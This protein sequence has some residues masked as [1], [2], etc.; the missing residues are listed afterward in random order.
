MSKLTCNVGEY[1]VIVNQERKCLILRLPMNEEFTRE[2]WM[3][4]GGRLEDDDQPIS[5]L[6]REI[7]EE[8]CLEIEV[9]SPVHVARWGIEEPHKYT[10]FF[11]CRTTDKGDITISNEHIEARWIDFNDVKTVPWLNEHHE[12]AIKNAKNFLEKDS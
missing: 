1:G 7:R 12:I 2:L 10:V 4:P 6:Q 3:L 5:G 9:I 11:L 8:T